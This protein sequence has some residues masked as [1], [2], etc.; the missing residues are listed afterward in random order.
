MRLGEVKSNIACLYVHPGS[1]AARA[2]HTV[3]RNPGREGLFA[4]R[5]LELQSSPGSCLL[6]VSRVHQPQSDLWLPSSCA[7]ND[8]A[9]NSLILTLPLY[10]N[11]HFPASDPWN[12]SSGL[13]QQP[14][15]Y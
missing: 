11:Y 2:F 8:I 15:N 12:F 3:P 10:P 13:L 6:C 7:M 9:D 5:G 4:T 14:P 1:Q